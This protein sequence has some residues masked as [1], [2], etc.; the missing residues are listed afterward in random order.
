MKTQINL[1]VFI[2]FLFCK[3]A[4]GNDGMDLS[5]LS[6]RKGKTKGDSN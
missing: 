3:E 4:R 1:K 2:R 6:L 5:I